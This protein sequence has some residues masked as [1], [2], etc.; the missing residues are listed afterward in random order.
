MQ[1]VHVMM[2]LPGSGKTT[3]AKEKAKETGAMIISRDSIRHMLKHS[4]DYDSS[5]R[6]QEYVWDVSQFMIKTALQRKFD[7]ILDQLSLT[8]KQRQGTLE[9]I[10]EY[11]PLALVTLVHCI[12]DKLNVQR[13]MN[14]DMAWGDEEYYVNLIKKLKSEVEEPTYDEGF[15]HVIHIPGEAE[16]VIFKEIMTQ[17]KNTGYHKGKNNG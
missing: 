14:S 11:A 9:F 5:S 16:Q 8:R 7:V 15:D 10:R 13:R 6:G 17:D 2:G 12:E 1:Y 4:H 3:W